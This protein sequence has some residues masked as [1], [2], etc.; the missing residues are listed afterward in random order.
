MT[1]RPDAERPQGPSPLW[2][3]RGWDVV[4]A[5]PDAERPHGLSPTVGALKNSQDD[6]SA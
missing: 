2:V 4:T 1:A 3:P 5:Q 6:R